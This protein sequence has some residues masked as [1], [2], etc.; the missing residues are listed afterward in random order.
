MK[1]TPTAI[2]AWLHHRDQNAASWLVAK[3]RPLVWHAVARWLPNHEMANDVVQETFI[4]VFKAMH[5]FDLTRGFEAWICAIARNTSASYLNA[6]RRNIVQPATDCGIED[7]SQLMGA[8]DV[9]N[10]DQIDSSSALNELLSGLQDK[11]RQLLTLFHIEGRTARD[12]GHR[13]GLS[14]CNVR[15]RM[16]RAH[17]AL[18]GEA[19]QLRAAGRL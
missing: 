19:T 11:D 17:R 14:E 18:R 5:R 12:V 6:W 16:M 13:L 3:Y 7:F 8:E 10:R 2:N 1:D 9:T 4:K 15:V